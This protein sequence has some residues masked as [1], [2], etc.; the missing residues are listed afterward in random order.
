MSGKPINSKTCYNQ[1]VSEK[2]KTTSY[3]QHEEDFEVFVDRYEDNLKTIEEFGN[4]HTKK[5]Y[6]SLMNEYPMLRCVEL[7]NKE[8]ENNAAFK[9]SPNKLAIIYNFRDKDTYRSKMVIGPFVMDCNLKKKIE[10]ERFAIAVG[11]NWKDCIKDKRLLADLAF[12]HEF[13]HAYDFLYNNVLATSPNPDARDY[14]VALVKWFIGNH[15]IY[16]ADRQKRLLGMHKSDRK[17][18]RL[19]SVTPRHLVCR[20]LLEKKLFLMIRRPPRSTLFPYT[21]LFRSEV[22]HR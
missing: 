14:R 16:D 19:N 17:S 15:G 10:A 22:V 7:V 6:T 11:A 12:L 8:L 21:T 2:L 13:G 20:L 5:L 4:E 3:E 1:Y 18:T 9:A